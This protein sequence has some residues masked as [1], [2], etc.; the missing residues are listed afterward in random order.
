MEAYQVVACKKV[1]GM[2]ENHNAL[3]EMRLLYVGAARG[4]SRLWIANAV[5]AVS[6]TRLLIDLQNRH[7]PLKDVASWM[8][9]NGEAWIFYGAHEFGP[10]APYMEL[11][12]WETIGLSDIRA[13]ALAPLLASAWHGGQPATKQ[14]DPHTAEQQRDDDVPLISGRSANFGLDG[15]NPPMLAHEGN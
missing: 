14:V 1:V 13:C 4:K 11:S 6:K 7:P 9:S 8:G 12:G 5:G 10:L 3:E 15:R 2:K